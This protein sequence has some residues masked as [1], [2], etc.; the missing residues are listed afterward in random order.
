ARL[1]PG[2]IPEPVRTQADHLLVRLGQDG[3]FDGVRVGVTEL[4]REPHVPVPAPGAPRARLGSTL[5]SA[6]RPDGR[7]SRYRVPRLRAVRGTE[8]AVV[9]HGARLCMR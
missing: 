2:D 7:R 1:P 6:T 8:P 3:L 9:L 4:P 5:A